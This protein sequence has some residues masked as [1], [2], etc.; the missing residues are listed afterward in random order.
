MILLKINQKLTRLKMLYGMFVDNVVIL[1]S[2][3]NIYL[4][5]SGVIMMLSFIL[6]QLPFT[7]NNYVILACLFLYNLFGAIADVVTDAIMVTYAKKYDLF[8]PR[9][10]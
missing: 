3:R 1:G 8:H 6:I 9:K 10:I 2:S 4:K 7:Q 5:I